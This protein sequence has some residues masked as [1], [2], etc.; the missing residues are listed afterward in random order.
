[1]SN[2]ILIGAQW[3]DEG[4][5][6]IIDL[7]AEKSD[8]IVRYQGGNNAGHTVKFADKKFVLHVIP[9]GILHPGKKCVIGNGVVV[10]PEALSD[11]IAML[12]KRGVSI[13]GRL[14]IS[15]QAHLIMPYHKLIDEYLERVK[16]KGK[17]GTTKKGI[18]P[19]YADKAA[20][21]GI[22]IVD[23][24]NDRV[25]RDRLKLVLSEKNAILK[26][27]FREKALSFSKIYKT[28]SRFRSF[29]K[30]LICNTSLLLDAAYRKKKRVLFEGAQGTLLDVDYGTY[31]YVTSSNA[32]AGG[33]ITGSGVS[34]ARIDRVIGVVKAYTTR[35]GEGPF[36]TEF[37]PDLM[38][39]VRTK[40]EEFG[41]T[42]GRPRRCGWFDAVI[43]RHSVL[44]NGLSQLAVM[45]LDV[46]D[47]LPEIKICV[48][49]RYRGKIYK[50]F[51][52]DIEVLEHG[53]PVYETHPGWRC[54]VEKIRKFSA[55]PKNAKRYLKR[56]EELLDTK[57][58]IVSV[59]SHRSQ[60]I[61]V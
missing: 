51:T 14:F 52:P 54:S 47:E 28:Y 1:M 17:I 23:L 24:M 34:P 16:G 36:P 6:K 9:S 7:L 40:G 13:A 3:G 25:F 60:T 43:A 57:V 48:A 55:L 45:K 21:L 61:F 59:G 37:P 39:H 27:I 20:R 18:G 56:L 58:T 22:R 49:Y 35:V 31:P 8:F 38:D 4:K 44:V 2:I 53:T 19:C 42:T 33:A 41:S 29:F 11:E 12:K 26:K 5:G 46:L 32:S 50:Y 15:E 30:P 10:D